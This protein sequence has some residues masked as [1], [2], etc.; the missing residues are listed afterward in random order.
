[1]WI[2]FNSFHILFIICI[3]IC[4]LLF[5]FFP[6]LI[7]FVLSLFGSS[8]IKKKWI[9]P[10]LE[11]KK[12]NYLEWTQKHYPIDI[13]YEIPKEKY[14]KQCIY[15][16]VP[17]GIICFYLQLL[18]IGDHFPTDILIL[19]ENKENYK[20]L[21]KKEKE[22][23]LEKSE[24]LQKR[25]NKTYMMTHSLLYFFLHHFPF[26]KTFFQSY[27][28]SDCSK[29]SCQIL[30]DQGHS[31]ALVPGGS[32]DTLYTSL[33]YKEI[34]FSILKKFGYLKLA[35]QFNIPIVPIFSPVE[36]TCIEK[37]GT[38]PWEDY[39]TK[40]LNIGI[41]LI[42]NFLPK[43]HKNQNVPIYFGKPI[44]HLNENVEDFQKRIFNEIEYLVQKNNSTCKFV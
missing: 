16:Y 6:L 5:F 39:L 32:R 13:H 43:K 23:I 21:E 10:F 19:E 35:K 30:L 36:D 38:M 41:P 17:H 3:I 11:N 4:I 9:L 28:I 40:N 12:K 33:D 29:K 22:I 2:L 25:S 14:P 26:I 15:I 27:P 42:K 18:F 1:M 20:N 31:I 8:Y 37:Y 24:N 44:Y 34:K 7:L